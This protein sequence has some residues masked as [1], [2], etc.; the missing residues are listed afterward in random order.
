M[1]RALGK[2]SRSS[3]GPEGGKVGSPSGDRAQP[4]ARRRGAAAGLDHELDEHVGREGLDREARAVGEGLEQ[5]A[6]EAG[7]APERQRLA[8][9][10]PAERALAAAPDEARVPRVGGDPPRQASSAGPAPSSTWANQPSRKISP[11]E[12]PASVLAGW[13][14]RMMP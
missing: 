3:V 14:V 11:P 10:E 2:P 1:A 5:R 8:G 12:S 13:A 4:L 9:E 6:V 7:A